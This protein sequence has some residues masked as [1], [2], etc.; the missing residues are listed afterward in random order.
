VACPSTH[1][2][3]GQPTSKCVQCGDGKAPSTARCEC[4]ACRLGAAGKAGQCSAC[5]RGKAPN[6]GMTGCEICGTGT[7]SPD[8]KKCSLCP[9]GFFTADGKRCV[10]ARDGWQ[11]TAS[12]A[13][14]EPCPSNSAGVNGDCKTCA[15]G[16]VPATN[17][18]KCSPCS[19]RR[20]SHDGMTC[21]P[22]LQGLT[23]NNIIGACEY[24]GHPSLCD[25][26]NDTCSTTY[27]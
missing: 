2:S 27:V 12:A 25:Y 16:H 11:S 10:Q 8:G 18:T 17:N 22:C 15:V 23:P 5:A 20:Y 24:I 13:D 9:R 4:V 26:Y 21:Q 7:A 19:R 6:A 1:V 3:L 14:E